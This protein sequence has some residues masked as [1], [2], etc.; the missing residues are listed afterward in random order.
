MCLILT[1]LS[2]Q[3]DGNSRQLAYPRKIGKL[4]Y[5]AKLPQTA[6]LPVNTAR[7]R[8]GIMRRRHV[9]PLE[10]ERRRPAAP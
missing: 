6:T 7:A 8:R 9:P 1:Q 5:D 4:S 2:H 10:A 3:S